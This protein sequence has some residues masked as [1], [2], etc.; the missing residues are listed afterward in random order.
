MYETQKP[1]RYALLR[2]ILALVFLIPAGIVAPPASPALA[3]PDE[4]PSGPGVWTSDGPYGG[5][6]QDIVFSPGFAED[7]TVF[8][9]TTQGVFKST[10]GGDSWIKATQGLSPTHVTALAIAPDSTLFAGTPGGGIFKSLDGGI[11]WAATNAGLADL[12]VNTLA[13]APTYLL[14]PTLLAGT[15]ERLY[16][17]GDGGA[18][19]EYSGQIDRPYGI[20]KPL[21]HDI[22]FSP[23]YAG[24]ATVWLGTTA[25]PRRSDRGARKWVGPTPRSEHSAIYDAPNERM[26]VF[27][28]ADAHNKELDEVWALDLSTPGSETWTQYNPAGTLPAARSCHSA[29]YDAANERMIVFGGYGAQGER[30]SDVWALDLSTPGAESWTQLSPAGTLPAARSYHSAIYDAPNARMIVFGGSDADYERLNDVWALDLSAPGAESWTQL[31]PSGTPPAARSEHGAI[32]D[33]S[34]GRM[35]VLGGFDAGREIND[36]WALDLNTPGAETWIA[37]SPSGTPPS[38]YYGY[39]SVIYDAPNERMIIFGG[40][41]DREYLNNTWALDLSVPGAE[42]WTTLD[43]SPSARSEHSAIYDA[44]HERMIV[45]GG[46]GRGRVLDDVWMLDLSTPGGETWAT[47]SLAEVLPDVHIGHSAIYDAQNKRMIIFGGTDVN[48]D[49]LNDVWAL[50]LSTPGL[51]TW[52]FLNP[53][54]T[55]PTERNIHH[56]IYDAQNERMII[57]GGIDSFENALNDV[58]ALDLSTPGAE[59]WS[60]LSPLGTPPVARLWHSVIYDASNEQ[61]IVFGGVDASIDPLND[62]WALSLATP[63]SETWTQLSPSGAPPE[64]RYRHSAIYDTQNARMIVFGGTGT[65]PP[66]LNDVWALSLETPGGETWTQLTPSETPTGRG[67]HSAVYDAQ[68]AQMIVFGG[69]SKAN[70]LND[71]WA[72]N[73]GAPGS[74]TW[75]QLS[76]LGTPPTARYVHSAIYDE[77]NQRMIV[78]GGEESENEVWALDLSA[79]GQTYWNVP[80]N[81]WSVALSPSFSADGVALIG[82]SAGILQSVDGGESWTPGNAGIPTGITAQTLAFS[83]HYSTDHTVFAGTGAGVY[84]STN[85]GI[86]WTAVNN[87]MEIIEAQALAVSPSYQND[88]T[89]FAGTSSSLYR[90]PNRGTSWVAANV[91]LVAVNMQRVAISSG[92]P[93]DH[94]VFAAGESGVY[95]STAAGALRTGVNNGLTTRQ[96]YDIA[97]SP[98]YSGDQTLFSA[99]DDGVFR[100]GDG[101]SGWTRFSNGLE[102]GHVKHL[103]LSPQF[104]TDRSLFAV[105][106][107]GKDVQR[108]TDAGGSWSSPELHRLTANDIALSPNFG[109]DQRAWSAAQ[110][111]WLA[112]TGDQSW[113]GWPSG[114]A[115]HSAIYDVANERMIVFGGGNGGYLNDTWALDLSASGSETWM[116]LN[117]LGPSPAARQKHS[118]IYDAANERMILFGGNDYDN[119]GLNDVWAL[120]LSTPGAEAWIQLNPSGTLPTSRY[121]HSAVYDATNGRMLVFGGWIK[122]DVWA[123]DLSTPGSETWTQ[124]NPSGTLPASRYAHNAIYDA[125]NERMII[126]G[127]IAGGYPN[128][129]AWALD[130]SAPGAEAWTQLSPSGTLPEAHI[131]YSA[132]YDAADERMIVF[133]GYNTENDVWALDLSTPEA[134]AWTQLGLSGALPSDRYR[135]SAIY[136]AANERMIVFGGEYPHD[137]YLNDV[138]ALD[139]Q[140]SPSWAQLPTDAAILDSQD[141]FSNQ[142]VSLLVASPGFTTDHTL[143]LVSADQLYHTADAG[144]NWDLRATL[145]GATDLILSP[146]YPADH[147]LYAV[148]AGDVYQSPDEGV[149]WTA[150]SSGLAANTLGI[151]QDG[152]SRTLFAATAN[153]VWRYT[154]PAPENVRT[155]ILTHQGRMRDR[156]GAAADDLLQNLYALAEHPAVAGLVVDLGDASAYPD[157]AAAYAAWDASSPPGTLLLGDTALANQVALAIRDVVGAYVAAYPN[158]HYLVLAGH[159]EIIPFHRLPDGT[160]AEALPYAG[161]APITGTVAL[162]LAEGLTLS[163][164][165]Y[166]SLHPLTLPDGNQLY[167]PDLAVGRLVESPADIIAAIDAF[168]LRSEVN[169]H[170]LAFVSGAD[171]ALM[172]GAFAIAGALRAGNLATA[173]LIGNDW[174]ASDLALPFLA[175]EH[176]L[177]SLNQHAYHDKLLA[178]DNTYITPQDILSAA[179]DLKQTLVFANGCHAGLSLPDGPNGSLGLDFPQAFARRGA[180]FLGNTGYGWATRYTVGLTE[181]L[182]LYFSQALAHSPGSSTTIGQAL[183]DAKRRYYLAAWRFDAYDAQ[184]LNEMTLYGLP[185]Y[186]LSTP[187]APAR[188]ADAPTTTVTVTFTTADT[189]LLPQPANPAVHVTYAP[190]DAGRLAA[191]LPPAV[192][193]ANIQFHFPAENYDVSQVGDARYYSYLGEVQAN[194]GMPLLPRFSFGVGIPGARPQGV[195]FAG[196]VYSDVFATPITTTTVISDSSG[197]N[198]S[199]DYIPGQWYPTVLQLVNQ[200]ADGGDDQLTMSLGKMRRGIGPG[201]E[202]LTPTQRLYNHVVFEVYYYNRAAGTPD[203]TPPTVTEVLTEITANSVHLSVAA[204]DAPGAGDSQALGVWRVVAAYTF[205][206]DGRGQWESRELPYNPATQRWEGDIPRAAQS[207]N[208]TLLIVQ[209]VD[210]GGNVRA[211]DNDG[212]YY[213]IPPAVA[214]RVRLYLPLIVKQIN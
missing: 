213:Q 210:R 82:T 45:F 48:Y 6:I 147:T 103:A 66:F 120:D 136:D 139:L 177:V 51:E 72:L 186:A 135:H 161:Y 194:R 193:Q 49:S 154:F 81:V 170:A 196:G 123:L 114:C 113:Q 183:R 171:Y 162:A 140:A 180:P 168:L 71:V 198:R 27:G 92:F 144:A 86:T 118:M 129:D 206:T 199:S 131:W 58:W 195:L 79:P 53:L 84:R 77:S 211:D 179:A 1:N 172:D 137:H 63:G 96:V 80:N 73:L 99:T 197:E 173:E 101:G 185:M 176:D 14:T 134:E 116:L 78:F 70:P 112:T 59:S 104:A 181:R 204:D 39:K 8:A 164:D 160:A 64:A 38:P 109:T 67:F 158:L 23:D 127:G 33:T 192:T 20:S 125:P 56:A 167:V 202:A 106:A 138:W 2:I 97:L 130:L 178:P 24:D 187:I 205:N 62:V 174:T 3:A 189:P 87:G 191:S 141:Y 21:I 117:P 188:A 15:M 105:V 44:L 5:N 28:G 153:G 119:Q 83:P 122:N 54:G 149:T 165:P 126:F 31:S 124:L 100:S 152:Q 85:A 108:S 69:H 159:D 145:T 95:K 19:W 155:L 89:V 13:V 157:V 175:Q 88:R 65:T 163:A 37:L 76:P 212:W 94:T 121:A 16:Y 75:A 91:G 52:T 133:G 46:W 10:N 166:A 7:H 55:P 61:M 169:E 41:G 148:A 29:I 68:N 98:C 57:F 203:R 9:A 11:S 36:V 214:D 110:T 50:D 25:G 146:T 47:F 142:A 208:P 74:E 190:P 42:A 132:V 34:N 200:L 26:I 151:A 107:D 30:F 102:A 40:W 184:V 150:L 60:Q 115:S 182:A 156:Y 12:N 35:I 32:Y 143:F 18:T 207:A 93:T 201:G 128:N 111:G 209:A 17:S 43:L 90:S 4:S 22:A